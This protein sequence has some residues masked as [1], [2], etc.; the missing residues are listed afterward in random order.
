MRIS[1]KRVGMAAGLVAAIVASHPTIAKKTGM[2]IHPCN[3]GN[4]SP[5]AICGQSNEIPKTCGPTKEGPWRE[6]TYSCCCCVD[7]GQNNWFQGG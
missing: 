6:S 3:P 7:G 5:T 2:D 4:C 1:W